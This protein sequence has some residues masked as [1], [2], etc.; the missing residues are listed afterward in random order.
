MKKVGWEACSLMKIVPG[1]NVLLCF[2]WAEVLGYLLILNGKG[3]EKRFI[4]W[5]RPFKG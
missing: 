2:L 5:N 1:I 3:L 4:Y